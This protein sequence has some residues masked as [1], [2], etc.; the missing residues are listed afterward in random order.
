MHGIQPVE[1]KRNKKETTTK[2]AP[3]NSQFKIR[4]LNL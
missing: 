3:S 2:K 1:H 4:K